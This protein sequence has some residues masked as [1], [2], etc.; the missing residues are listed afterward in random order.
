MLIDRLLGNRDG[1]SVDSIIAVSVHGS[2]HMTEHFK[3]S[4]V[5]FGRVNPPWNEEL[6]PTRISLPQRDTQI[7]A[8]SERRESDVFLFIGKVDV[9]L[10]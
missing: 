10:K 5:R 8:V 6:I 9:W 4:S 2:K 7:A 1:Y 3:H